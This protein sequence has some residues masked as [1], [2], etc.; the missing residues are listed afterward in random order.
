M[1]LTIGAAAVVTE[2]A[3][4]PAGGTVIASAAIADPDTNPAFNT[5][6]Y[7][8]TGEQADKFTVANGKLVLKSGASLDYETDASLNLTVTA[9]NTGNSAH[10]LSQNVT[11]AVGNVNEAPSNINLSGGAIQEGAAAGTLV[12][13]LAGVDPD[14][15]QSLRYTL[16]DNAGGRFALSGN[17]IVVAD[18]LRL[19]YEQATGHQVKVQVADQ[20]GLSYEKIFS[21]GVLDV[22]SET[23]WGSAGADGLKGGANKDKFWGAGGNDALYG[24][25]GADWLSGGAGNDL[26]SGGTGQDVFVFRDKL[27]KTTN[28]DTLSDFSVK[29]DTLQLENKVFTKLTKTGTLSKANF[30]AGTKAKDANDHVIYDKTK[31]YVYYDADGSGKGKAVLFAKV[32]KGLKLNEKDFVV[33]NEKIVGTTG[34]DALTGSVNKDS[35]S[36]EAGND[37]LNGG[38]GSDRLTGGTGQDAFIFKNKLGSTNVDRISDFSVKDDTIHLEN[39]IFS[40][41]TKTGTLKKGFFTI[42]SEAKD[43]NDHLV[44]NNKTGKLYYDADGSG[45][46]AQVQ[47]ATLSKNLKMTEKDFFIF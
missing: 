26:L 43:A 42:G 1:A 7:T 37:R 5:Y 33:I 19:D 47:F 11:V 38:A 20:G 14:A 10:V 23:L 32:K 9:T 31:G 13:S 44:Y 3:V 18:G 25:G 28:V 29:D 35:L 24:G 6:T 2:N 21:I 40:K 16:L 22:A 17:Q 34:N 4:A 12:A 36:G 39:K 41:L 27:N 45:A 8:V 30:I 15:G 46:Q